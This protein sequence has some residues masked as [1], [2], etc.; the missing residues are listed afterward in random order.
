MLGKNAARGSR[1]VKLDGV[2]FARSASRTT[3][4]TCGSSTR[5]LPGGAAARAP[6]AG[7]PPRPEPTDPVVPPEDVDPEDPDG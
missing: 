7:A 6:A 5:H 4:S 2:F 1:N 3:R